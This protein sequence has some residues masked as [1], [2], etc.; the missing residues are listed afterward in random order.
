M[1]TPISASRW[2][3]TIRCRAVLTAVEPDSAAA[4]AGLQPGDTIESL[5][6][7]NVDSIDALIGM[8]SQVPPER[9]IALYVRRPLPTEPAAPAPAGSE[10]QPGGAGAAPPEKAA[11]AELPVLKPAN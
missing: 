10:A 2:I 7:R 5:S 9:T 3:T 1:A 4:E 11:P 8:L 6:G